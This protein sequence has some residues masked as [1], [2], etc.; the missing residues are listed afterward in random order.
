MTSSVLVPGDAA[1][2]KKDTRSLTPWV[3]HP[4]GTRINKAN[5]PEGD[6]HCICFLEWSLKK[7]HRVLP[8]LSSG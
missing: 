6:I 3:L 2:N 5:K 7:Y 8:W 1:V 4:S